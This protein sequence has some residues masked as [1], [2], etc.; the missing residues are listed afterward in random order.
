MKEA[1]DAFAEADLLG[2]DDGSSGWAARSCRS[3]W[4]RPASRGSRRPTSST[5]GYLM[6]TMANA[7][8]LAQF[9]APEQIEAFLQPML[10][11]RFSGT[12]ALSET[13]AGSSLADITHPRRTPRRRHLPA[14]RIEDVDL[15]RRT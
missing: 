3:P 10:T 11:G 5:S 8:L 1:W 14:V 15:R 9:G 2:D 6:L 7:N 13:Q 4:P 12:M